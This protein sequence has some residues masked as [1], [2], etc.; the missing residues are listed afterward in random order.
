M[1]PSTLNIM[2]LM[3]EIRTQL[4]VVMPDMLQ[5]TNSTMHRL[6]NNKLPLQVLQVLPLHPHHQMKYLLHHPQE[7]PQVLVVTM[8]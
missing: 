4:M 8:Q 2:L 6:L 1:L 5:L 3:E 7:L